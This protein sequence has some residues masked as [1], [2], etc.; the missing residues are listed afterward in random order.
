[1]LLYSD[2]AVY[3][4][5]ITVNSDQNSNPLRKQKRLK[6]V[7]PLKIYGLDVAGNAFFQTAYTLDITPLGARIAGVEP[8]L[9][10]ADIIGIA[11]GNYKARYR[12]AWVSEKMADGKYQVGVE[13]QEQGKNVWGHELPVEADQVTAG[14]GPERR[15][16]ERRNLQVERFERRVG[17]RRGAGE[18][19][20][21]AE[22]AEEGQLTEAAGQLAGQQAASDV[23]SE[24]TKDSERGQPEEATPAAAQ[25]TEVP[26]P[27]FPL[28]HEPQP[29][30]ELHAARAEEQISEDEQISEESDESVEDFWQAHASSEAPQP[31]PQEQFTEAAELPVDEH[32][33]SDAGFG[34]Q[35]DFESGQP[36]ESAPG[37]GL[38]AELRS[39]TAIGFAHFPLDQGPQPQREL[40]ATRAEEQISEESEESVGDD[41]WQAQAPSEAPHFPLDR[42]PQSETELHATP[43]EEEISE[44][45]DTNAGGDMWQEALSE[46]PQRSLE[47]IDV[48]IGV[49]AVSAAPP[50]DFSQSPNEILT[51]AAT[52]KVNFLQDTEIRVMATETD[53]KESATQSLAAE[54]RRTDVGAPTGLAVDKIRDLL[55]GEQIRDYESRFVRLEETVARESADIREAVRLR[56]ESMDGFFKKEIESLAVRLKA[57]SDER[58]ELLKKVARDMKSSADSLAQ[59]ITHLESDTAVADSKLRQELL[60]KVTRLVEDMGR[61]HDELM[62]LI[63]EL[64]HDK[65]DRALFATLLTGVAQNVAGVTPAAPVS[66]AAR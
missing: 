16:K 54:Q 42:E 35:E 65:L 22:L 63:G 45:A 9:N 43:A 41:V 8:L 64:R 31:T 56:F 37:A 25:P 61:K 46:A 38:P 7:L 66:R 52:P 20:T 34:A 6:S 36:A 33:A 55:L 28:D 40:H 5:G 26:S 4:A 12:V 32:A 60:N 44:E 50:V 57:E 27:D 23:G 49:A 21:A 51:E 59:K 19:R 29:Q 11:R 47:P 10:V 17:E 1:L 30:A 2:N 24:A 15:V 39:P 3:I 58:T 13:L 53:K 48:D 14:K 62:G 18:R